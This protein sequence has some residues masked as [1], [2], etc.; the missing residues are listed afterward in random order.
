MN[1]AV[2]TSAQHMFGLN[3]NGTCFTAK[4]VHTRQCIA[5]NMI[6]TCLVR[7]WLKPPHEVVLIMIR[8]NKLKMA[9]ESGEEGSRNNLNCYCEKTKFL[10]QIRAGEEIQ[11]Q[12]SAMDRKQNIWDNISQKLQANSFKGTGPAKMHTLC[13]KGRN[14]FERNKIM[15]WTMLFQTYQSETCFK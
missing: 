1:Y 12:L 15:M 8:L 6:E 13:K 10:V 9:A 3:T 4:L 7:S 5:R 14:V 11:H 2:F